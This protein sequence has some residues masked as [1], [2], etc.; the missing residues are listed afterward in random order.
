MSRPKLSTEYKQKKGTLRPCREQKKAEYKKLE[1]MPPPPSGLGKAGI[2]LWVTFG[3]QLI[4]AGIFTVLDIHAF[5]L[6]CE[7]RDRALMFNDA[8]T[9]NGKL[10][11]AMAIS[12]PDN[13]PLYRA[14]KF[15][16]ENQKK[17]CQEFG[18]SPRARNTVSV[19]NAD[20]GDPD[21]RRMMELIGGR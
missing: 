20:S 12:D 3:N 4:E 19:K 21:A 14:F 1:K 15:E 5:T 9:N 18:M 17:L 8:L 7:S 6:L 11:L 13:A 2:E 10:S 16:I